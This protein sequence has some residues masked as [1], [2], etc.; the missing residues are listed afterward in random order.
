MHVVK[1]QLASTSSGKKQYV[2]VRYSNIHLSLF[3]T[4]KYSRR[5]CNEC[6]CWKEGAVHA[7]TMMYVHVTFLLLVFLLHA[8]GM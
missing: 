3:V 6:R 5:L 8:C 4:S 1:N 2:C 7:S